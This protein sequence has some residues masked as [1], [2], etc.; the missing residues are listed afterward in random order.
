MYWKVPGVVKVTR[1]RVTP[2]AACGRPGRSCGAE[3]RRPEFAL[4]VSELITA[5][6]A[7]SEL[8]FTLSEGGRGSVGSVPNVTV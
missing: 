1:N 8:R 2:G 6:L 4:P 3:S 5:C 7:P